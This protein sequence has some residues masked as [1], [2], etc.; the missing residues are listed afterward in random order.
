MTFPLKEIGV[1]V[2]I[3]VGLL[4]IGGAYNSYIETQS[5][6]LNVEANAQ[7]KLNTELLKHNKDKIDKIE[8]RI[9]KI[10]EILQ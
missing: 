3:L 4:A 1:I 5:R 10:W 8:S 7:I 6:L 9:D 2:A